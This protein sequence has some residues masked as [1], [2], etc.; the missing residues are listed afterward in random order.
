MFL[1]PKVAVF[2]Q[3]L[4]GQFGLSVCHPV[5][6]YIPYK[7]VGIVLMVNGYLTGFIK[8][9]RVRFSL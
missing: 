9:I 2:G 4:I 5:F 6:Q 1:S 8:A 3:W 7:S